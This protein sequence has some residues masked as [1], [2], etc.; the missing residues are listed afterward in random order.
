MLVLA[1][2]SG[3]ILWESSRHVD[4]PVART[5]AREFFAAAGAKRNR[6]WRCRN[7]AARG[8]ITPETPCDLVSGLPHICRVANPQV[9]RHFLV[10]HVKVDIISCTCMLPNPQCECPPGKMRWQLQLNPS[11]CPP[12]LPPQPADLFCQRRCRS[13]ITPN[14]RRPRAKQQARRL[15]PKNDKFFH[16]ERLKR[17]RLGIKTSISKHN[18][19]RIPTPMI[20]S[21]SPLKMCRQHFLN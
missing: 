6:P 21:S 18:C 3:R 4:R 19:R 15:L 13:P 8:H 5:L 20:F 1:G 11:L 2:A 9:T 17:G 7:W 16:R 14:S 10:P 12:S